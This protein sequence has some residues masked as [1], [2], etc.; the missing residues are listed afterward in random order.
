MALV[1]LIDEKIIQAPLI[2][3]N[4]PDVLREL[5]GVLKNAG[6]IDDVEDALSAVVAR[7]A[8]GS[9]GLEDGIAVPHAKTDKVKKL[10]MAIGISHQGI[11]FDSMDGKPSQ[12]FFLLLAPVDQSGPHLAALAEIAKI[13]RSRS[14]CHLLI[15]AKS[16]QEVVAVFKEDI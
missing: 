11:D 9:T 2:S 14:F 10:A 3:R 6:V 1:D 4:K 13:A 12:L 5:V 15:H 16:P 7:E 8:K